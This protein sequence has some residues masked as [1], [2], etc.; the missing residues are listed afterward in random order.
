MICI[1]FSQYLKYFF[2]SLKFFQTGNLK[3]DFQILFTE[4]AATFKLISVGESLV[5]KQKTYASRISMHI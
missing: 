1:E 4:A 3:P 5:R 2:N